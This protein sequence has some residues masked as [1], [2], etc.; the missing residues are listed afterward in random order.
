MSDS[1]KFLQVESGNLSFRSRNSA[2]G[3][4]NPAKDWNP[5]SKF[6]WKRIR[7]P[8]PRIQNRQRGMK[9]PRLFWIILNNA[10]LKTSV[11]EQGGHVN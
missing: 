11:L 8:L 2:Q 9:N 3:I 6:H 10:T 5:E 4:R 7:N 1:G